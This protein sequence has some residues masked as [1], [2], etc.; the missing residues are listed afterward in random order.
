MMALRTSC[1]TGEQCLLAAFVARLP[2][3]VLDAQSM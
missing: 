1:Q 3:S 2:A